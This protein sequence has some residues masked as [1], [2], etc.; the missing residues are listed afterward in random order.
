[1]ITC[2]KRL[3][4]FVNNIFLPQTSY[5]SSMNPSF[6]QDDHFQTNCTWELKSYGRNLNKSK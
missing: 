6:N 2:I 4:E 5:I 1:M 3:M